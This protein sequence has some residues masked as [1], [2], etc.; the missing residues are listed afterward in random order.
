MQING[1]EA[2]RLSVE[3]ESKRRK[4]GIFTWALVHLTFAAA[5]SIV[6]LMWRHNVNLI[7][8]S[9]EKL[10]KEYNLEVKYELYDV[11]WSI[12]PFPD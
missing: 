11:L 1:M 4:C 8:D 12:G 5:L 3:L 7:Q 9:Y 6:Y 10:V 2:V